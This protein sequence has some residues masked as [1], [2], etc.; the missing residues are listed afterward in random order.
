VLK[1]GIEAV[2]TP[3][4]YWAS[5]FLKEKEGIDVYDFRNAA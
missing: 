2:V 5:R 3:F 4:T 1:C